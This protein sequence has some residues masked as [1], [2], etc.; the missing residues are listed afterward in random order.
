M[1]APMSGITDYPFRQICREFGAD[2][3]F[4]EVVSVDGLLYNNRTTFQILKFKPHEKPI[5]FQL[6]GSD[7]TKF[8]RVLKIIEKLQPD[9]ID[10]NLGCP[11][12]KI[13]KKGAGAALL[14]ELNK[15]E[16]IISALKQTSIPITAK[17][18]IGWDVNTIVAEDVAKSVESGGADAITVHGRT[19][20][21]G[22][23]GKAQWEYIARV[24]S[25]VNIP[26]IGNGDVF[27][28]PSALAMFQMT[29]VD[30]IM[31]A[32]GTLGK[33]WLF[34]E[35]QQYLKEGSINIKPDYSFRLQVLQRHYQLQL[36][37][38]DET[39]ALT[40]MKK[41]LVWYTRGLPFAARI[42]ERV[43]EAKNFKEI[44]KIF[45]DYQKN[46]LKN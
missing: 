37:F 14:K 2:L 25:V 7:E 11:M 36:Q 46:L 21:Q 29:G 42:K 9:I 18:R 34:A 4:T 43:F 38:Y 28:G 3:T 41:H 26:V 8:A 23:S 32:R 27:D 12:K 39:N 6:F 1:L 16:K 35:I 17:I 44:H 33:P 40:R 10:V 45:Q 15:I 22:Y 5:G 13:V 31:L 20:E 19:K 30:G 24:K